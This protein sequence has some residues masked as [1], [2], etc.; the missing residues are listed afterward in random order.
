[1][2]ALGVDYGERR[3]GLALSDMSGT[4]A[5]PWKTIVNPGSVNRFADELVEEANRVAEEGGLAAIVIGLPRRLN[6]EPTTLTSTVRQLARLVTV[7]VDCPVVLQDERLTSSEA[8]ELLA[9]R[10]HDWR[11]RKRDIDALSAALILQDYLD[12][13][14][15]LVPAPDSDPA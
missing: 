6:G 3:I 11:R 15:R 7:A 5:S 12:S 4:L 1:M 13:Q 10:E 9:R 2:R 8:D 14:S